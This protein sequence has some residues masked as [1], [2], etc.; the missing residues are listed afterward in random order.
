MSHHQD[1][2]EMRRLAE[3]YAMAMDRNRPDLLE[4]I[5]TQDA[6]LAATAATYEGIERILTE[7]LEPRITIDIRPLMRPCGVV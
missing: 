1:W 7:S 6:V 5:F 4:T 2:A 3:T